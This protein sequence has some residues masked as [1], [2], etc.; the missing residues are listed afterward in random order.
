MDYDFGEEFKDSDILSDGDI[1]VVK[2]PTLGE[3]QPQ[4]RSQLPPDRSLADKATPNKASTNAGTGKGW[5]KGKPGG[6][7]AEEH[8]QASPTNNMDNR[9]Q[10]PLEN[11]EAMQGLFH[12][13]AVKRKAAKK[14]RT[15]NQVAI[16]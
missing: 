12:G 3:H 2:N 7:K 13:R 1:T 4:G 10:S 16:I 9:G 14:A 15:T 11:I 5:F 6:A 8:D